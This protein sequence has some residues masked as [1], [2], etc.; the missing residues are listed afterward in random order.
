MI[1]LLKNSLYVSSIII[2]V[3][4]LD[5]CS[6]KMDNGDEVNDKPVAV[7][8][9]PVSVGGQSEILAS[10]EVEALQTANISTRVMGRITSVLVK[11]GDKVNKGQVL[12]RV[13]DEDLKSRG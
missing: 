7:T 12:A 6:N 9:S 13:W 2:L 3:A 8:L 5:A 10:G 11:V 4:G 1:T